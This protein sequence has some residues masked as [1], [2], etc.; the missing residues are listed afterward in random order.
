MEKVEFTEVLLSLEDEVFYECMSELET[1]LADGWISFKI[2]NDESTN[3]S[4]VTL[5]RVNEN[6]A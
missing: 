4:W 1:Y 2:E 6:V 3:M 5:R